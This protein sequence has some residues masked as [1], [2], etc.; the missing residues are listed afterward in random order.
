LD[1]PGFAADPRLIAAI[2]VSGG[3]QELLT[4]YIPEPATAMLL[5]VCLAMQG[6]EAV[7]KRSAPSWS[8][9]RLTR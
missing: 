9:S 1:S 7:R 6:A 8:Y 4:V 3:L 2:D 5:V